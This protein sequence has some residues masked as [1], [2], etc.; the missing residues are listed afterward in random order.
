MC[1]WIK[2]L[3]DFLLQTQKHHDGLTQSKD[4]AQFAATTAMSVVNV[5]LLRDIIGQGPGKNDY[6][7]FSVVLISL[8][9]F[10]QFLAGILTL[11]VSSKLTQTRKYA[12]YVLRTKRKSCCCPSGSTEK[13][14]R[15][16]P[17]IEVTETTASALNEEHPLS[18][19]YDID[20]REDL[21]CCCCF[22]VHTVN[23][24]SPETIYQYIL[25][26]Q[27]QL[28]ESQM[29]AQGQNMTSQH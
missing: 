10:L 19:S 20:I 24:Y 23:F 25:T 21:C 17:S 6:Y 13:R 29:K 1:V 9:I 8:A 11:V 7:Y 2:H 18:A 3:K 26:V 16:T 14:S 5:A 22:D 12:P 4:K 15:R 28:L 27:K